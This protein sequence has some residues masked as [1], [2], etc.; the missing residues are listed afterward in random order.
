MNLNKYKQN[1]DRWRKSSPF[2][3]KEAS[4]ENKFLPNEASVQPI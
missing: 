4:F 1:M 2:L 3:L